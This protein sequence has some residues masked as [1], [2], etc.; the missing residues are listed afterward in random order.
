M[1]RSYLLLIS[2]LIVGMFFVPAVSA[3]TIID[4][5]IEFNIDTTTIDIRDNPASGT[6]LS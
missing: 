4:E 1:K 6:R 3:E 2:L 5:T